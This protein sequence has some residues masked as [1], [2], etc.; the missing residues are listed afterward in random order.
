MQDRN[1]MVDLFNR[2]RSEIIEYF[3]PERLLVYK[4][5]DAWEAFVVALNRPVTDTDFPRINSRDKTKALFANLMANSGGQLSEEAMTATANKPH[6][7]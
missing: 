4:V 1:H 3:E 2:R 7:D 5:S 6:E